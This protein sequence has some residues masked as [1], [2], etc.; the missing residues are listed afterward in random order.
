MVSDGG[1]FMTCQW[2]QVDDWCDQI[3]KHYDGSYYEKTYALFLDHGMSKRVPLTV[4]MFYF[5][6]SVVTGDIGESFFPS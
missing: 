5:D 6:G 2:Y 1:D 4:A 3:R